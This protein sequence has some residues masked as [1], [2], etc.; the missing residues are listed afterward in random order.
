M[1]SQ[2]GRLV[3]LIPARG[4]SK[5][6]PLKNIA[7]L[8][9][10]PLIYWTARA[11][12]DS[13]AVAETVIATD[14]EAIRRCVAELNLPGVTALGRSAETAGDTATTESALVEF[15]HHSDAD[16][17][18]LVQ[19]TSPLLRA[20]DIDGAI[21]R[22]FQTGADSLLTVVRTRRFLWAPA[23]ELAR[24]VNY[25]P[26]ARPRRQD[27]DG[28]LVENGAF[29]VSSRRRIL[30]TGCRISGR[31][32]VYEMPAE[33]YV[34]LDE[35]SDWLIAGQLLADRGRAAAEVRQIAGRIRLMVVDVDGTLTD[36][37]MYYSAEGEKLKKFDTR[38]AM[39]LSL[40]RKQGIAVAMVTSEDTPI[41]TA[42][43]AKMRVK[44]VFVGVRDKG[45]VVES[46]LAKAGAGWEELA[47]VGDDVND[48]AVL[49]R[50]G[51]SAC[52]LDAPAR[53]R[54]MVKYVC[55]RP[56]GCGAVREVCELILAARG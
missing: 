53:T 10:R 27:W 4:G 39:G 20:E 30:E 42:R 38:D 7:P 36:G 14:S 19:A 44:D 22:Y 3:A 8:A 26:Q 46:L 51:L 18:A 47:Y 52:P 41:V 48:H 28:Q 11:C 56:G 16:H 33:T 6:I 35:P 15:A 40:L 1:G 12:C 32:A 49:S 2:S 31:M 45:P 23:G 29:Y 21:A 5:S 43:A 13:E 34:E 55:R 24:P 50:A 9:G 17:I 25:D 54:R 37:G